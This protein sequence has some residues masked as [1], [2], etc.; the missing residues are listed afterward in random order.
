ME[1]LRERAAELEPRMAEIARVADR[2]D[3]NFRRY[4]DACYEKYTTADTSGTYGGGG[5]AYTQGAAAGRDWFAVYESESEFTYGGTYSQSTS[6]R[7]E[8]TP[9]CRELWSD[10]IDGAREV[11]DGIVNLQEQA[12]RNG[13]LPGHLRDLR[14]KYR[15]DWSGWAR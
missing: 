15:L 4:V 2:L 14:R 3:D 11:N 10:V 9:Y 13:V 1:I 6:I 7:N 12:R 8:S 5:R